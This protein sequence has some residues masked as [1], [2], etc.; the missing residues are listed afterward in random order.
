MYVPANEIVRKTMAYMNQFNMSTY[1]NQN[2]IVLFS[3]NVYC[4]LI[5]LCESLT[6]NTEYKQ[7]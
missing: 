4:K 7:L 6:D 3:L 1:T 5:L 2:V